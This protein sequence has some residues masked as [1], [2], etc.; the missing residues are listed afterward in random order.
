MRVSLSAAKLPVQHAR[1]L[2]CNR[3]TLRAS[4]GYSLEELGDVPELIIS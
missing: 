2:I 3:G 4:S 1:N